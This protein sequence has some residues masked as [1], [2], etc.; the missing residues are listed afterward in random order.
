MLNENILNIKGTTEFKYETKDSSRTKVLNSVIEYLDDKKSNNYDYKTV[1]V[2][3][4]VLGK[5]EILNAVEACLDGWFTGGRFNNEFEKKMQS[6]LG[7]KYFLTCNSGS[8]ANLLAVSALCSNQLGKQ[9]LKKGD[10]VITCAMGFPT[11]INP[12]I[13]NGLV[14]VFLDAKISNYNI[15]D[16]VL[17]QAL[18]KKTKAIFIAHTLGN[19]FNLDK[20]QKFAKK[21]NLFLI[22]DC[23]DAL[24][25]EFKGKKVG[26]FGDIATLSFYPAHHITMGEGGG[27]FCKSSKLKKIIESL[28]DWG[29]DCWCETGCD[30]TC[31]KRFGWNFG[32]LPNGYDHKYTYTNLGYNLKITDIQAAIGLAQFARLE[33]F[34]KIRRKNFL[35]LKSLLLK[36]NKYFLLPNATPNSN[37]S[38]FGF[39]LTIKTN[40]KITR[41]HLINY[42]ENKNISTRLLFGGNITKQPYM[43]NQ[44]YRTIGNLNVSNRIMK[45]SFWVGIYPGLQKRHLKYVSNTLENYCNIYGNNKL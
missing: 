23:C 9:K 11:T 2:S 15:N 36:L 20:I 37:P 19:P 5:E 45:N 22:E 43:L 3:G 39:P 29:R 27:I 1:P 13:Q 18:S 41:H 33:E 42:L 25:A 6:F 7:I 21:Y 31:K 35:Y 17:E 28:R 4:K 24:G 34:I 44:K 32:S 10:E 14:P 40:S 30:N 26:T 16:N 8:S 38:W 12:I